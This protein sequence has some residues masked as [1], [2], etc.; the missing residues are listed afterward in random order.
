MAIVL[1]VALHC[2]AS[3]AVSACVTWGLDS[4]EK[5]FLSFVGFS[6][7][8]CMVVVAQVEDRIAER[9]EL[10]LRRNLSVLWVQ[11]VFLRTIICRAWSGI[12]IVGSATRNRE[13]G[14]G[15]RC[16]SVI[17]EGSSLVYTPVYHHCDDGM[18][19]IDRVRI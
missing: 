16:I 6:I 12:Y 11:R 17:A 7:C 18:A 15:R 4:A 10:D 13:Y 9:E 2:I 3:L 19:V 14:M 8:L 5:C 1:C